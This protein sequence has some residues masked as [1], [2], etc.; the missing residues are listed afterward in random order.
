MILDKVMTRTEGLNTVE[1]GNHEAEHELMTVHCSSVTIYHFPVRTFE[2]FEKKVK[3]YGESLE[4]N[5]RFDEKSSIHLRYWYKRYLE[6]KL[7]QDYKTIAFSENRLAEL[8]QQNYLE[9]NSAIESFY[10]KQ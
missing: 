8:K 9:Y 6:G 4:K 3:N 10:T 5:T 1:Y 7:L 2:Q